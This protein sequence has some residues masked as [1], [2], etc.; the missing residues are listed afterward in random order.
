MITVIDL[1]ISAH[2]PNTRVIAVT[3]SSVAV[4]PLSIKLYEKPIVNI[5]V[6][7]GIT[8]HSHILDTAFIK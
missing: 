4:I 7:F 6:I 5:S 2:K 8:V 1:F 3:F